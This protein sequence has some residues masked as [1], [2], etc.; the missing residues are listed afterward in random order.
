MTNKWIELQKSLS[1]MEARTGYSE[2]DRIS[3]RTL[4]WV[5]TLKP[6]ALPLYVQ[7]VILRCGVA[8]PASLH[9][10]L[11]TL[12]RR[13]LLSIEVDKEDARRRI[14]TMTPKANELFA[15]LSAGVVKLA[16]GMR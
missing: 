6:S 3:Q 4:E 15:R 8:S 9:K 7:A 12:E 13:G 14:V 2:L 1:D 16:R 5:A 10:A 11:T